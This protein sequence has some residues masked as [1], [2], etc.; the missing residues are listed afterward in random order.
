MT[1][2]EP[3][4]R[5]MTLTN[6]V[7]YLHRTYFKNAF[8]ATISITCIVVAIW[9]L[10]RFADWA[11]VDSVVHAKD[12]AECAARGQGACWAVI[13]AR[14]QLILFGLYPH[15][16]LW[17]AT[18]GCLILLAACFLS[19]MPRFWTL[20]RLIAIWIAS[21]VSFVVLMHGGIL[22]LQT[23][24]DVYWG[25]VALTFFA[26]ASMMIVGVPLAFMLALARY[27]GAPWL[28][29]VVAVTIDFGRALPLVTILFCFWLLAPMLLPAW[30]QT[31]TL[32]RAVV[33]FAFFFACY[34]A[35]VLRGGLQA[36]GRGQE[37]AA[38][39]LGMRFWQY[40]LTVILPQV[41]RI[42][43]PQTMNLVVGSFKDTSYLAVLGFF[44]MVAA[45]NAAVG[46]GDWN[47]QFVEV[48]FVVALFYL[49]F[50]ISLS[51]YG[52]YLERRSGIAFQ[53]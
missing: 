33:G 6:I 43:L 11:V 28:K 39:S 21:F 16:E 22:G 34:E 48:Y 1:E 37:E 47:G 41:F 27:F 8:D 18:V 17:R 29:D 15:D 44:D 12:G 35:E 13:V 24:S 49:V 38:K 19:C 23:V 42:S 53:H 32:T 46:S 31:S 14:F 4:R 36:I 25:G 10:V 20:Y 52:S 9:V 45:S 51:R 30:I 40:Q 2:K 3:M 50:G 7:G 5:R 26:F